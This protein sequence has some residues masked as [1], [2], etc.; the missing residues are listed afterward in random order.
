MKQ[1]VNDIPIRGKRV[2]IRVD[3]NVPL[4]KGTGHISDDTRIRESLPTIRYC[5]EQGASVVLISHLGRPDGHRVAAYSLK[6]VATELQ[7][8]LQ[9]PVI[10]VDECVGQEVEA[11]VGRLAPGEIALLENLRFHAEEERNDPTFAQ[12]LS[13]LGDVYVNDAFGTAHR[14]HASTEGV[15][16]Y[17]PAVAGFLME[18]EIRYLDGALSHPA[19]PYVAILGGAKV[20]DKIGVLTQLLGK[21]DR[22]LIGGGMSYTFLK[23]QGRAIGSSRIEADK[24]DL[25]KQL[26]DTAAQ[27]KIQFLLPLDHV[28]TT[29]LDPGTPVKT[30]PVGQ[31]P[32]GWMGADIGP[33]TINAF[34]AALADAKTVVWNGPVGVFEQER[35]LTGS[36]RIAEALANLQG[37]TT[38]I[39]GGDSA[40]CVQQLKL[41]EKMSHIST[42]GGASLEF[43]E[44]KTLPG[45]AILKD[46]SANSPVGARA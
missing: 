46:K 16:H 19:R 18:K 44:G 33:E 22:V 17:L 29:S 26:L 31:I 35:F 13:R 21:V 8:L 41:G 25:A 9:K 28:I 40:A 20:S 23:A 12:A 36:R 14:A 27:R 24:L 42:G 10:F 4:E 2:L 45:I 15:G 5:L 39:G 7:K 30:V 1:T 34:T 11:R 3:F 32:D 38:I 43:L 6:V 37:A